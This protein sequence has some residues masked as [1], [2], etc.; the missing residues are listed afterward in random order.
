MKLEELTGRK[1]LILGYGKEGRATRAFLQMLVPT[2]VVSIADQ[3]DGPGY[4]AGLEAFDVVIKA[5][6][7]PKSL[8]SVPYTTATN[9]FFANTKGYTIGVT[10]SKGKSTTTSLLYAILKKDGRNVHLVGN[11]GNPMLTALCKEQNSETVYVIELSS[12][13]LDDILYS[14]RI[15]LITNVFPEHMDYHGDLES[16]W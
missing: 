15:S 9:I 3:R 14:P 12:Y 4:L 8:L 1:I 2:A 13:Q 10:G 11:I 6:G 16:Y 7:I 5:P